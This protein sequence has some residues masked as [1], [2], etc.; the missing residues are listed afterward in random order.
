V[1]VAV[2]MGGNS[3]EREVSLA[4]G[5]QVARALREAGHEVVAV[6]TTR[7]A[8]APDEERGLLDSGVR[9]EAPDP[10]ALDLLDTGDTTAL[11][12]DPRVEE[13]DVVFVA[14]HGGAGEDGTIQA[15][16]DLA[17]MPYAGSGRIGCTLAMDKDLSKRIFRDGGIPT[18]DWIT[19]ERDPGAVV[20]ELGLPLIVKPAGGGST[21]GLT[22]VRSGDEIPAAVAEALRYGEPVMY[23]RFVAGR[24]LTVGVLG[25]E[26]LPVGEIIPAHEIFDYE[27]KYQEGMA[28]EIFPA[29][30]SDALAA[31]LQELALR[32]HRLLRLRDFSRIDFIVDDEGRP[33]CLEANALP[34][35]T[36]TSLL[37]QAAGAA[38]ISFPELCDRIARL[39][40]ERT[41]AAG[42][43][44]PD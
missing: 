26:A 2:L 31:E 38:G 25:D 32:A 43:G 40:L 42:R 12:R 21:L 1:K 41:R 9:A 35:M 10:D 23:E 27:C 44:A 17:G 39:A 36:A 14:L 13:T 3:E 4:S 16:L 29:E 18:P 22:L 8:L 30:I 5:A 19:G 7:G 20:E 37:P 24:E 11:T 34:G 33:W 28:E 15:L 6:D